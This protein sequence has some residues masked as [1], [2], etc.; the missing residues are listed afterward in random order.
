M[1]LS[2]EVYSHLSQYDVTLCP[3]S[4]A[5]HNLKQLV[6]DYGVDVAARIAGRDTKDYNIMVAAGQLILQ[7]LST[8]TPQNVT[9]Y[10]EKLSHILHPDVQTFLLDNVKDIDQLLI[11]YD[12]TNYRYDY[13]SAMSMIGLYL[14]RNNYNSK[15]IEMPIHLFMRCC[16][17]LYLDDFEGFKDA[18]IKMCLG[19][20]TVPSAAMLNLGTCDPQC[21]S[22]FTSVVPDTLKGISMSQ[23]M[24]YHISAGKGGNGLTF[25]SIRHSEIRGAMMS[26]GLFDTFKQFDNTI[27]FSRQGRARNGALTGFFEPWHI[28]TISCIESLDD[29]IGK[30]SNHILYS[31][32]CLWTPWVFW[33]R[34]ES[35]G[36]WTLF[37]PKYV[38][39]LLELYGHAFTKRY[40]EYEDD[41]TIPLKY[42]KEIRAR[43][44]IH[45]VSSL[46]MK[47]GRPF[48]MNGCSASYKSNHNHHGKIKGS[49]LCLE[50]VENNDQINVCNLSSI[51]L[52]SFATISTGNTTWDNIIKNYD[53]NGLIDVTHLCVRN[54]NRMI[55]IKYS[56]LTKLLQEWQSSMEDPILK[57]N[58]KYRALG[59]G[60]QGL[61]TAFQRMDLCFDDPLAARLDETII[62]CI[63][64]NAV[65]QSIQE[66]I[67]T[68]PCDAHEGSL[69]SRGKFQ[70]D[71]WKDE[72]IERWN[73][74]G[75]RAVPSADAFIPVDPKDWGQCDIILVNSFGEVFTITASWESLREAMVLFGMANSLLM[76]LMPTMSSAK[77]LRNSESVELHPSNIY[78]TDLIYG[79][80]PVINYLLF[81]DLSDIGLWTDQLAHHIIKCDGQ[82]NT[83]DQYFDQV[84]VTYDVDRINYIKQ[85]YQ[86][87]M[88]FS[89][90]LIKEREFR[91]NKYICQS[92]SSNV[93]MSDA[94]PQKLEALACIAAQYGLKTIQYY[95]YQQ[96][97]CDKVNLIDTYDVNQQP[98]TE[99]NPKCANGL[100][101]SA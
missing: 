26:K 85:K 43:D 14:L 22:C 76:V 98:T 69:H 40:Q 30:E 54:L 71:N 61:S 67:T 73:G 17:H 39:D 70:F 60:V 52:S 8:Q 46:W 41:I 15:P 56:P 11:E 12:W 34:L 92:S 3:T 24:L 19:K 75:C 65:A 84:N 1:S 64:F 91:R 62:A 16:S 89:P 79:S 27:G 99:S 81:K 7:E 10:V 93:Y 74:K 28:D 31:D 59:L 55:N 82:I 36:K 32:I 96:S 78:A 29:S 72:W 83:I 5:Q 100:C 47:K 51:S 9:E 63:Y 48:L 2:C 90:L 95:L 13:I 97:P 68:Q 49:N 42:R 94:T 80:Y 6:D 87:A 45:I 20:Y 53:F 25:S 23:D 57:A 35:D 18:F 21:A 33:D 4:I 44:L 66:A 86:G 88:M 37:C 38:P 58:E 77:P 101:C 50:I